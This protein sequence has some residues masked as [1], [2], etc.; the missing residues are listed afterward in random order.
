MQSRKR[1]RT[2]MRTGTLYLQR[3]SLAVCGTSESTFLHQLRE[4]ASLAADR[5][6]GEARDV[7]RPRSRGERH[8]VLPQFGASALAEQRR[9][10]DRW[11]RAL[12]VLELRPE[13]LDG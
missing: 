2:R 9:L 7:L 6:N 1:E 3:D 10:V 12:L 5:V 13:R 8:Q 4:M 11:R